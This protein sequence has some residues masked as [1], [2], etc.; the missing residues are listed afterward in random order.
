M[1]GRRIVFLAVGTVLLLILASCG[2]LNEAAAPEAGGKVT[3]VSALA[4]YDPSDP[5]ITL[6]A[7]YSGSTVGA[8][9]WQRTSVYGYLSGITVPYHVQTFTVG[10]AGTYHAHSLQ[11][12]DG[13]LHLYRDGF[14][15]SDPT[16]N[17]VAANDDY[18]SWQSRVI[19]DLVPDTTYYLVTSGYWNDQSGEFMNSI[20][21][22]GEVTG[23]GSLTETAYTG[24]TA[25]ADA[26]T[27]NRLEQDGSLSEDANDVPYHLQRIRVGGSGTYIVHSQQS[28]DGYLHLY[29]DG[30]DPLSPTDGFLVADDDFTMHTSLI[31]VNLAADTTYYLVTS[32]WRNHTFGSFTN[33]IYGPYAV[34]LLSDVDPVEA[35]NDIIADVEA[36]VDEGVLKSGQANGLVNPLRNALRS[37]EKEYVPDACN[38][39]GDFMLEVEA[40]VPPLTEAQADDLTWGAEAIRGM[41]G[42]P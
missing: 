21:G 1:R 2:A 18:G 30:F 15:P 38:Q 19:A 7:S 25:A 10:S 35:I 14:D 9:T 3:D 27:W 17:F 39:L 40:K 8:P 28:Y 24:S 33:T 22:P 42:C 37:L 13:F 36:L 26:P 23:P 29:Q 20:Y 16:T 4:F 34:S 6:R 12:Y 41:L 11:T 31:L 5:S 32:G